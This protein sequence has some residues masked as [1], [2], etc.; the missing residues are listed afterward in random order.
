MTSRGGRIAP[1]GRPPQ[2]PGV[3]KNAK[4]HDLEAPA[5]PGLHGSDLQ[6][7]DVSMLEQGQRVAPRPKRTQPA[8]A[9]QPRPRG[10][11]QAQGGQMQVPDAIQFASQRIGGN[12]VSPGSSGMRTVDTKAWMPLVEMMATPPNSGGS[13]TSSLFSALQTFNRAPV[14]SQLSFVDLDEMDRTIGSA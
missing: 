2:T 1:D 6:Q 4:R 11:Q 10:G 12:V 8:A 7:G 3:G 9:A 14:V 5:T 13:I